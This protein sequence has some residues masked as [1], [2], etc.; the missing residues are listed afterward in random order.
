MGR[1]RPASRPGV[2][3]RNRTGYL[4]CPST[5]PVPDAAAVRV[6]LLESHCEPFERALSCADAVAAGWD[7]DATTD[8]GA[9]VPPYRAALREAGLREPLVGALAAAL[10]ATDHDLAADPVAAPPYLV[11]TGQG[12]VLRGP[13]SAAGRL[14]ATLRAFTV[15]PYRRGPDLP[16]ALEVEHL[17]G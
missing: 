14:V 9:V 11:V 8:R 5:P 3:F 12:V 6:R 2:G 17:G 13:L 10:A 16:A 7:G 4:R 15:A 1:P